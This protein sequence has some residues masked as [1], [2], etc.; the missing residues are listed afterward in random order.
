MRDQLLPQERVLAIQES[1]AGFIYEQVVNKDGE[2][3]YDGYN[4]DTSS[5][6]SIDVISM[7]H[8]VAL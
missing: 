5:K 3:H 4:L 2:F 8:F 1:L 6:Y 7:F